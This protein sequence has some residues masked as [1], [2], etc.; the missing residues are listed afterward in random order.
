MEEAGLL[1]ARQFSRSPWW[2]SSFLIIFHLQ[3]VAAK[4][5]FFSID[6]VSSSTLWA[7]AVEMLKKKCW[8]FTNIEHSGLLKYISQCIVYKFNPFHGSFYFQNILNFRLF[9]ITIKEHFFHERLPLP[10]LLGHNPLPVLWVL[11]HKRPW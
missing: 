4:V 2:N 7:F 8:I 5:H 3:D 6:H 10:S 1:F 9:R 11:R